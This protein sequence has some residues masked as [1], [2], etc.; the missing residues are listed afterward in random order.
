[1]ITPNPLNTEL[2][3]FAL[4]S[5]HQPTDLQRLKDLL[6]RGANPN[7]VVNGMHLLFYFSA[8]NK[9]TLMDHLLPLCDFNQRFANGRSVLG[10]A[11]ICFARSLEQSNTVGVEKFAQLFMDMVVCGADPH[12]VCQTQRI[13]LKKPCVDLL[14]DALLSARNPPSSTGEF[15]LDLLQQRIYPDDSYWNV[16]FEQQHMPAHFPLC[17]NRWWREFQHVRQHTRIQQALE[18]DAT[19]HICKR[20]I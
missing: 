15:L 6:E 20:K 2:F 18:V 3:H 11:T 8:S 10:E 19:N 7:L 16:D 12:S 13:P 1:M 4:R 5:H 9:K 17:F 14:F